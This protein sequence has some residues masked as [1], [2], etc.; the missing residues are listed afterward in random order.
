MWDIKN[1]DHN[2]DSEFILR[3][4]LAQMQDD[5]ADH[6]WD[7]DVSK[8]L[9]SLHMNPDF[10]AFVNRMRDREHEWVEAL[11]Q[12]DAHDPFR[13]GEVR[14]RIK[15]LRGLIKTPVLT[16]AEVELK[17]STMADLQQRI[18]EVRQLLK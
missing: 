14:G 3:Q 16:A 12:M 9:S 1:P 10:Q 11:V 7:L 18:D 2:R 5:L 15:M 8:S 4:R 13:A 17:M 6:A